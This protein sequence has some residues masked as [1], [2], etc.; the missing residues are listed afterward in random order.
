MSFILDALKKSEK[1]RQREGVPG[2]ADLPIVV[3]QT[4]TSTWM[5]AVV[6]ALG[7]SVVALIWAWWRTLDSAPIVASPVSEIAAPETPEP[8][9]RAEPPPAPAIAAPQP[10]APQPAASTSTRSLA[11]EAA[12]MAAAATPSS[13]PTA[14]TEA[15]VVQAAPPVITPAPMS[16]LQARAAG[17]SVPELKLELLVY[18][19]EPAQRF[20]FIN[21]SKYVEGETLA[22]G[23]RLIEVSP[24]GAILSY[25]GQNFL[26][27][28]E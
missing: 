28:Q 23:P 26:L 20:V 4:R 27:P 12:R 13:A 22:D 18:S 19:P 16:I 8:V 5:V 2:I 3:R 6:G 15:L 9:A 14:S 10:A 25:N 1:E 17:L 24:E 7:L 11:N 21:G